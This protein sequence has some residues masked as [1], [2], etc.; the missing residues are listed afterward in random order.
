MRRKTMILFACAAVVMATALPVGAAE[1]PPAHSYV[2]PMFGLN[3]SDTDTLLVADSGAGVVELTDTTAQLKVE[4]PGLSDAVSAGNGD[5]LAVTGGG[6]EGDP[7]MIPEGGATL[8]RFAPNADPVPV[9]DLWAFEQAHNPDAN[10]PLIGTDNVDSNPYD[11]ARVSGATLVAD[12]GG[13]DLLAVSDGG[14]VDWM[15]TLPAHMASTS[16]LLPYVDCADP[17]FGFVCTTPQIPAQP[18]PTTVSIGPDGNYYLGELTGFP[19]T[20]GLSR[21]WRVTP[22]T[23]HTACPGTGCTQVFTGHPFTA[24]IDISFGPDG[25]MY[26]LEADENGFLAFEPGSP[27]PPMGGTLN[28]CKLA[29][30]TCVELATGLQ[31][32]TAVTVGLNGGIFATESVFIPG[33]AK[34]KAIGQEFSDDNGN[35]HELNIALISAAGI[36]KGCNPPDNDNYCPDADTTRGQMAAFINRTLDLPASADDAFTDDNGSVFEA[37]INALAAA[38]ITKGCNPPDNDNYCPEADVSRGEMAAFLVRALHL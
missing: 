31:L 30:E 10:D 27:V 2:G 15:V 8:Y 1:D 18:V 16:Y 19:G 21:I 29:S 24:I 28:A 13:N 20:P 14:S 35:V 37:D 34:V 33:Q 32:S 38:G 12:A 22:G 6:A 36:T 23:R 5:V 4:F 9:A 11:L 17:D 7:P 26:V 25:T 3:T